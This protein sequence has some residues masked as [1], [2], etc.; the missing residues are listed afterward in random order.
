[1]F[2]GKYDDVIPFDDAELQE[3]LNIL[4]ST[5]QSGE[6]HHYTNLEIVLFKTAERLQRENAQ[7]KKKGLT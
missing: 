4:K 2:V 1:M 7:L 3:H 6:E 5:L